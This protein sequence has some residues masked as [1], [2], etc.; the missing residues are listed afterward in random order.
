[1]KFYKVSCLNE[2]VLFH[3]ALRTICNCIK[4][5][6]FRQI[7]CHVPWIH[8][9]ARTMMKKII[10]Y[11]CFRDFLDFITQLYMKRQVKCVK[12]GEKLKT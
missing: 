1:M 2:K 11:D 9:R 6:Y 8:L 12:A 5:S 3:A 7:P 4:S 10:I